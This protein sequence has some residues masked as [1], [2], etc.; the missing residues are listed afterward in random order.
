M[1]RSV[2]WREELSDEFNDIDF[3]REYFLAL[4]HEEQLEV[5]DAL[6]RAVKAMGVKEF[7][8]VVEMPAS[9]VSRALSSADYKLSTFEKFLSVFG[10]ELSVEG[11]AS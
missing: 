1:K 2:Y 11:N 6:K 8:K 7:A 3:R 4:V 9:N 5:A 10:L